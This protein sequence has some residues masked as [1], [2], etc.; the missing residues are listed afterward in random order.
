MCDYVEKTLMVWLAFAG[1]I[2]IGMLV[3]GVL[4]TF[5]PMCAEWDCTPYS[6]EGYDVKVV[7][8]TPIGFECWINHNDTYV[9]L[10]KWIN[11]NMKGE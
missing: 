4:A 5:T 1:L 11:V 10:K 3:Y 2:M 8:L 6:N 9:P 7:A